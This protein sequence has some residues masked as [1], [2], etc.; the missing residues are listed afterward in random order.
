MFREVP[1][2]MPSVAR[3]SSCI[4]LSHVVPRALSACVSFEFA[5]GL[6]IETKR[7]GAD[8]QRRRC[9]SFSDAVLLLWGWGGGGGG[10][11]AQLLTCYPPWHVEDVDVEG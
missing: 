2:V 9:M 11:M 1:R 4:V 6:M 10:G 8:S 3:A 5:V 7:R